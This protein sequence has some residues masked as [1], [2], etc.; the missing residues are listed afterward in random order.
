MIYVLIQR[1][2]PDMK[3]LYT[4]LHLSMQIIF[5]L[6]IIY[7]APKTLRRYDNI[8]N[9]YKPTPLSCVAIHAGSIRYSSGLE[10]RYHPPNRPPKKQSSPNKAQPHGKD[11]SILGHVVLLTLTF[12]LSHFG[13]LVTVLLHYFTFARHQRKEHRENWPIGVLHLQEVCF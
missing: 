12:S 9:R 1:S 4:N 6:G 7:K 11:H 13:S 2:P 3:H 10:K 5:G 8:R